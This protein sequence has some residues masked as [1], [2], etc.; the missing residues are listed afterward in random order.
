MFDIRNAKGALAGF[1][2]F[3]A[4]AAIPAAAQNATFEDEKIDA[5]VT[6][7][8]TVDEIRSTYVQQFEAAASD[9]ERREISEAAHQEMVTAVNEAPG[10]TVEEYNAIVEAASTDP[11]LANRLNEEL[12]SPS[13]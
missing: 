7:Q 5:F 6:A 3:A 1:V 9:E 13:E 8:L 4:S 10:I 12:A 2:L 11:E